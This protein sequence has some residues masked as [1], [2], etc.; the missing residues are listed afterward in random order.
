M[1]RKTGGDGGSKGDLAVNRFH[2][3]PDAPS[4]RCREMLIRRLKE[5]LQSLSLDDS[6]D[7]A[8]TAPTLQSDQHSAGP[9]LLMSAV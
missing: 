5:N 1:V 9:F 3:T 7:L 8:P 4:N 2:R 6:F